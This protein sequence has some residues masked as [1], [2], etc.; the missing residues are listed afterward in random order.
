MNE[1]EKKTFEKPV[2]LKEEKYQTASAE[3][4]HQVKDND[5]SYV[6]KA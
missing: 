5:C 6:M 1:K 4:C 3:H 2:V